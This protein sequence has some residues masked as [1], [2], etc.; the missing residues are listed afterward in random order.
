ML[1]DVGERLLDRAEHRDALRGGE[2]VGVAADLELG[3]DPGALG[4]VV[5][6]AVQDLAEWTG[7]DAL[8]LER[9]RDLAQLAIE[10][11]EPRG[12]VVEAAVGLLAV[13]LED[14]W[15]DLLLQQLYV[16]GE[17]EDVLDRPVVEIEP[18]PHQ[19]ALRRRDERPLATRRVLEQMLALDDGAERGCGLG[20]VRLRNALLHRADA[21]DHRRVRLAEAEHRRGAQ[22]RAAE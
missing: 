14:E 2:R 17:R 22:L 12:Q 6:L 10:L 13:V 15:I 16:G 11:D 21:P 9:V 19:P 8:R 1:A 7:D 20:E 18:E 4:E 3:V 5:D